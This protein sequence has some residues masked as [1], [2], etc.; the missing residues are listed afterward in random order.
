M[1]KNYPRIES[2][3]SLLGAIIIALLIRTVIFEPFSIPSGSMKP[4]FLIGDY[5]YVSKYPYGISNSSFL[6]EPYFINGRIFEFEKPQRGEVIV[7]KSSYDRTTN[8]IKRLI[9]LPGD[10]IQVKDNILYINGVMVP[11]KEAGTFK[12]PDDGTVLNRY[13]ETLPNNVSYYI[14]ENP[15]GSIAD[16]TKVYKVPEGH[17]F[18]MGDNRDHS[19]DSRFGNYPIGFVPHNKLIG[20]AEMVIFSNQESMIYFFKWLTDFDFHRFFK[21]IAPLSN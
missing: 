13:V 20:R 7:F 1:L 10:E 5:L 19:V 4:N 18:M 14:I 12:D 16:N 11:R 9:G 8:Y 21:R 6:F 3:L 2:S 17:Y 15:K